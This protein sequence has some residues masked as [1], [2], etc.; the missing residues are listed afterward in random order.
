MTSREP[1]INLHVTSFIIQPWAQLQPIPNECKM[2]WKKGC[3]SNF[4]RPKWDEFAFQGDVILNIH[5]PLF[6]LVLHPWTHMFPVK[7]GMLLLLLLWSLIMIYLTDF[8][9]SLDWQMSRRPFSSPSPRCCCCCCCRRSCCRTTPSLLTS[10]SW[11]GRPS[12]AR[13]GPDSTKLKV[14]LT[15]L[16]NY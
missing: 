11:E 16:V 5:E 14:K 3:L 8:R 6:T 13:R 7:Y 10:S 2:W 9:V 4:F 12:S 1:K 15:K